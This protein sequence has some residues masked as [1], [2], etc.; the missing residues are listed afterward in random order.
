M[1]AAILA[2]PLCVAALTVLRHRA[3]RARRCRGIGDTNGRDLQ[4]MR[5]RAKAI[6]AE[7]RAEAAHP[8]TQVVV[9]LALRCE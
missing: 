1:Q 6:G 4:S 7:L 8:G 2:L 9:R 5:E 3:V